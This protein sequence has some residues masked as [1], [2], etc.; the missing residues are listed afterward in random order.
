MIAKIEDVQDLLRAN[1]TRFF[2]QKQ[3]TVG[4]SLTSLNSDQYVN[5]NSDNNSKNIFS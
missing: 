3:Y 4:L 1:I 2:F 5:D